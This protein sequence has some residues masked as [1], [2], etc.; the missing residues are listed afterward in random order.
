MKASWN[1]L[2][3]YAAV[4]APVS[5]VAERLTMAGLIVENVEET[6]DDFIFQVEITSNRPD[7]LSHLG[8]AREIAALYGLAVDVPKVK[9]AEGKADVSA[10]SSLEVKDADLCPL[11]TG[12]VIKGIKVGPSPEWLRKKIEAVGLRSVNNVVDATNF[13]L[14]ECGQPLHA[15][16]LARVAGRKV[17]VR[18]AVSGEILTLIDG[19]RHTLRST[20]LIIADAGHAIALAGVMGGLDSE[21]GERT[22][23]VFLESAKFDQY[24]VRLSAK[25]LGLSTDA[26]YRFERG[27]DLGTVDWASRR[28]AALIAQLTGGTV[29]R[30][31]L[32]AGQ[33]AAPRKTVALR[34]SR[35]ADIL[36]LAV[37]AEE[38]RRILSALGL[39]VDKASK[40]SIVVDVPSFRGDIKEEIDLIEEVA[41]IHG[42]D[43]IPLETA[44]RIEAGTKTARERVTETVESVL[45]ASGLYGCVSFS[46]VSGDVHKGYSPW[47][48]RPPWHIE[49]RAGQENAFMRTSL[50]PSLLAIRKTN[51]S[52]KVENPEVYEVAHVYLP[53]DEQLPHQPLMVAAVTNGE[54]LRLKG[55]VRKML[56][57]LSGP[58]ARFAAESHPYLA[59]GISTSIILGG[60]RIGYLGQLNEDI[61]LRVDLREPV[62]VAEIDLSVFEAMPLMTKSYVPLQRFP[63]LERDLAVV[64]AEDVTWAEISDCAAKAGGRYLE[65]L[66]FASLYRGKPVPEGHKSLA[67]HLVFRS[68]ERTLTSE[69]ADEATSEIVKALGDNLRARLR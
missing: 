2:T 57:E 5:E 37:P 41:R 61:R 36:G 19:S 66:S 40:E 20:D 29:S 10:D 44:L 54:F 28:C 60:R 18:R 62:S 27:V 12:R 53:S 9:L 16:D 52:R 48:D 13:V 65:G 25:R 43:K 1:W 6:A 64:V 50:V 31:V 15:F 67:F 55:I 14:Y 21:I 30:G 39:G 63:A 68:P 33:G 59:P 7:W 49:N 47:T 23:E 42:Y 22:T 56:A 35:M 4:N 26:S 38:V 17:V 58:D 69:E 51:E 45:T 32:A 46:L 8:I 24:S 3:D 34:M 11:Y